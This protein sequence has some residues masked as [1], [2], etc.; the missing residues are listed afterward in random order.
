MNPTTPNLPP[1][2]SAENYSD[3][4][5]AVTIHRSDYDVFLLNKSWTESFERLDATDPSGDLLWD[6]LKHSV[7]GVEKIDEFM[8]ENPDLSP[9]AMFLLS[10]ARV[11][12]KRGEETTVTAVSGQE[13]L[14][15][16]QGDLAIEYQDYELYVKSSI[17]H[18]NLGVGSVKNDIGTFTFR[19]DGEGL[20]A[21]QREHWSE[22]SP[23]ESQCI[24][25][26]MLVIRRGID[27]RKYIWA[28]TY[29]KPRPIN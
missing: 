21:Y 23:A 29:V 2:G 26:A 20:A 1:R 24:E 14:V 5:A 19:G 25:R 8:A 3:S 9:E 15:T 6:T 12:S 4:Q 10:F 27:S 11:T 7:G 18:T 28:Q 22:L 17:S 16:L 13:E